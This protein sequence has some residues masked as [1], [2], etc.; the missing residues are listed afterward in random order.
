[1]VVKNKKISGDAISLAVSGGITVQLLNGINVQKCYI[2]YKNN[3]DTA[4]S[5]LAYG[6]DTIVYNNYN[7]YNP[8]WSEPSNLPVLRLMKITDVVEV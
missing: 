5:P 7:A 3:S 4:I 2:Y 1:M 8:S 6:E